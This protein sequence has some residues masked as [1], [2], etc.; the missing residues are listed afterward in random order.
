[1]NGSSTQAGGQVTPWGRFHETAKAALEVRLAILVWGPAKSR[2]R[3]Y[4]K[5]CAYPD[6][7]DEEKVRAAL[8]ESSKTRL[9]FGRGPWLRYLFQ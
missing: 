1:M 3:E 4:K 8:A 7:I 9:P 2:S 6:W 5:R